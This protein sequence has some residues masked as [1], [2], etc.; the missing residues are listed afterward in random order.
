MAKANKKIY[1]LLAG[2]TCIL[3]KDSRI[4]AINEKKDIDYWFDLMPELRILAD[5]ETVLISSEDQVVDTS[6]WQKIAKSIVD[7]EKS[8]DGFVVV[9]KIDQLV[10]TSLAINFLLQNFKKSIIFTS[11]Q[12]SG[13]SFVDKKEVI[14]K[15]KSKH[16]GLGLRTNLINAIQIACEPLPQTAVLFGTRLIASTKAIVDLQDSINNF[17]SV[18]GNYLAKIDFGINLK[19]GLKYST[20][21]TEIY[22]SMSAK[23]LAIYDIPGI[24]WQFEQTDMAKYDGLFIKISPFQNLENVKIKKINNWKI[25]TV[26]FN[27]RYV[28]VVKGA[29]SVSGCT[30]NSA[31]IKTIWALSN[32]KKLPDFENVMKQNIIGEFNSPR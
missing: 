3:D 10:N 19:S 11:S 22:P 30:F 25:P 1:L 32:K 24:D 12:V 18:E 28:P 6:V 31:L 20:K 26:I 9:T 16:G 29:V 21:K 7:R 27:S 5:I 17:I 13:S 8:A 23:V 4:F 2:G 15:L 14:N